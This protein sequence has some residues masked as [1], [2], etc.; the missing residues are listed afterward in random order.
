M[1]TPQ[2]T[3]NLSEYEQAMLLIAMTQTTLLEVIAVGLENKDL[4]TVGADKVIDRLN[5]DLS[6]HT[7]NIAKWLGKP[8]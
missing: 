7:P 3:A 2:T 5:S 6:R 8:R 1:A 4:E